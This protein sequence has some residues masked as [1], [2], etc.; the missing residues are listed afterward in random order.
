LLLSQSRLGKL[1][2]AILAVVMTLTALTWAGPLTSGALLLLLPTGQSPEEHDLPVLYQPLHKG[3]VHLATGHYSREDEDLIVRGTPAL[4]LRRTHLAGHRLQKEFGIGTTHNGERYLVG[5][6]VGF[7]WAALVLP[8]G[9]QVRFERTSSGSSYGNAMYEHRDSASEWYGAQLGWTGLDWALRRRDGL[10]MRFN[11]CGEGGPTTCSIVME[12]DADGHVIRY[13][14]DKA[15][16]LLRMEATPDRW[17]AFDYDNDGRI[18][19]AF[20][21]SSEHVRYDYD[22][23]G[24]LSDVT[25]SDGRR[26]HYGYSA[27]H[28][29]TRVEDPGVI[30]ENSYDANNRCI[31]QVNTYPESTPYTFEFS[32]LLNGDTVV[33]TNEARSDGTWTRYNWDASQ[34]R[35]SETWGATGFHPATFA[36]ERDP[37]S[38][39]VTAMTVTCPSRAGSLHSHWSR[40]RNGDEER[41]RRN[42]LRTNCSWE[43]ADWQQPN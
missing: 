42:L 24:R 41:T 36:Y 20:S 2:A 29:M 8:D 23:R 38:H 11:G 21:S 31:R 26:H 15:G 4:V 30:I 17:I 14:R 6:P 35:T 27:R 5:D 34:Q 7:Q 3:G 1:L 43:S 18:V 10:L 12:R 39:V 33:E 37:F 28:E 25:A 22:D 40:V 32:Y 16:R 9:I 19:R 13:Q